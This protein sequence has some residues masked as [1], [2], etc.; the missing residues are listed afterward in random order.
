MRMF[1]A[2]AAR[3]KKNM[4]LLKVAEKKRCQFNNAVTTMA[5]GNGHAN[6]NNNASCTPASTSKQT[7]SIKLNIANKRNRKKVIKVK[8][9]NNKKR[10]FEYTVPK[11]TRDS[12]WAA[13][14][15]E[16]MVEKGKQKIWYSF[17]FAG[18]LLAS[19]LGLSFTR[20]FERCEPKPF[21]MDIHSI[22]WRVNE[23]VRMSTN[24]RRLGLASDLRSGPSFHTLIKI[25]G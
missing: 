16:W 4:I 21:A 2:E 20:S 23:T 14:Q 1:V 25:G 12:H 7:E 24:D 17:L 18:F 8:A 5:Y 10:L 15:S 22:H 6:R 9:N 13:E 3:K 19:R 11:R